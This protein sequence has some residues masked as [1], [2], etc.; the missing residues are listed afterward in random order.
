MVSLIYRTKTKNRKN[1]EKVNQ[2]Q[3]LIQLRR[4]GMGKRHL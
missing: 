2:K 3:K 1:T 4:N